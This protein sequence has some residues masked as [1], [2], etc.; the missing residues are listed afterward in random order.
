MFITTTHS[1][2]IDHNFT[3]ANPQGDGEKTFSKNVLK[4][5]LGVELLPKMELPL[6]TLPPQGTGSTEKVGL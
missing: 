1:L 3:C 4:L 5:K 6:R 2:Q